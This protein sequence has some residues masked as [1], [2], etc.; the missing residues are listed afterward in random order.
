MPHRDVANE[1]TRHGREWR[2]RDGRYVVRSYAGR[3]RLILTRVEGAG[4]TVLAEDLPS[5]AVAKRVA[6]QD[7]AAR[8]AAEAEP[9]RP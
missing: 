5:L 3:S 7:A 2:S 1:W 8:D 9:L 6:G 4:R